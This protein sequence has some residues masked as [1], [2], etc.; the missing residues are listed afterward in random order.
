VLI[1]YGSGSAKRSGLIDKVKANIGDREVFEFGG[2]E[3]TRNS[4]P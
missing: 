3:P 1:T 4:T 2:I